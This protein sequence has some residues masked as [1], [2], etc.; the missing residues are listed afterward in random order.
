MNFFTKWSGQSLW[1][2]KYTWEHIEAVRGSAL[3][4]CWFT[5]CS[6]LVHHWYITGSSLPYRKLSCV[7]HVIHMWS[8]ENTCESKTHVFPHVTCFHTWNFTCDM[9][10][11]CE[12]SHVWNFTC[13]FLHVI[14]CM[15]NIACEIAF[16]ENNIFN[17]TKK[18]H[19][20]N[21][22]WEMSHGENHM[23]NL[24]CKREIK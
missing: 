21:F 23:G 16:V 13:D 11:T 15:W 8:F 12:I 1:G 5:K 20:W 10:I 19:M 14:I 17:C 2:S 9:L 3:V 4:R 7:S 22:T 18:N 6:Y 24:K